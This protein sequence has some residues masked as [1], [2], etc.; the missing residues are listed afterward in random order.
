MMNVKVVYPDKTEQTMP[1]GSTV[2]E[3]IGIWK[4]MGSILP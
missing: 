3:V 2:A 1:S 4:K